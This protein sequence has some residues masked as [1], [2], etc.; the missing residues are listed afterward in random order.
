MLRSMFTAISAL[1]LHQNYLDVIADNLANA[2]TTG[3]KSSRVLIQDQFSQ[4]MNPGSAPTATI[5]GINPTQV[6][7]GAQ[8]GYIS[9]V[10][11]QGM[12]QSTGR[13]LDL[14]IQGDGFFIYNSGADRRYSREGALNLDAN[15]YLVNGSTGLHVQGWTAVDGVVNTSGTIGDLQIATNETIAKVTTAATIAGN[16]DAN[17]AV[18]T[19]PPSVDP[20]DV[21]MQVYDSLGVAQNIT[22][23]FTRADDHT[24]NWTVTDPATAAGTGTLT[25][26]ED[27]SYASD[28]GTT[29]ITF[30]GS[31]GSTASNTLTLD[32]TKTTMMSAA[33]S[34]SM[35]TQDGMTAGSFADLYIAPNTGEVYAVYTNGMRS[36]EGQVAMARFT[37]PTGLIRSGHTLFQQGV[38]SGD[39]QVGAASTGGRGAI[40]SGYLEGS[41]VD[42]AQEF[43][44]MILAQRGFQASSRVITTSDEILQ[45]LVNLKR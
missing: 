13:S 5:G 1:N 44:N 20:I 30:A 19:V 41:N 26:N 25:F 29:A 42:M 45:E 15:N 11:T 35:T 3:F 39:P 17:T 23:S 4:L 27:G 9:P 21:T 10:F 12:L 31:P 37:N 6:G 14:A 36:L 40:A 32:L 16:L 8:L 18:D 22:L 38:N 7:L 2:N 33:S 43:T 28:T 34:M 24:W